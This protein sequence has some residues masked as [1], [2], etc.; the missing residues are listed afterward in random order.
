MY[1]SGEYRDEIKDKEYL[2][3]MMLKHLTKEVASSSFVIEFRN[4]SN[5]LWGYK[6]FRE[7]GYFPINWLR[8]RNSLHSQKSAEERFSPS[9]IRQIKKG[10]KNGA[11]VEKAQTKEEIQEFSQMLR[12]VY[13][14]HIRKHFPSID[15]FQH[16]E[17]VL[18]EHGE[19]NIFILR[20][21]GK[22][23]GGSA[24]I[25]SCKDVFLWFEG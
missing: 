6:F 19:A 14:I 11:T 22:V 4:L 2:F 25:Y 13:S 7:N 16:L 21:N 23:I 24:C 15:F 10:L 1:G 3:G 5:A 18:I 17:K 9:R 8:V 12:K 20:Y